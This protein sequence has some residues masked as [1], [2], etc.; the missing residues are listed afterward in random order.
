MLLKQKRQK[1][2]RLGRQ[3]RK[4]RGRKEKL[5]GDNLRSKL[6]ASAGFRRTA[7]SCGPRTSA[8]AKAVDHC[9]EPRSRPPW[10]AANFWDHTIHFQRGHR[11]FQSPPCPHFVRQLY[12]LWAS[13]AFWSKR[14]ELC[15]PLLCKPRDFGQ[16]YQPF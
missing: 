5:E 3:R 8:L 15:P 1:A 6:R 2:Q 10:K 9:P 16:V 4:T 12:W 14:P 7:A 11:N 13:L